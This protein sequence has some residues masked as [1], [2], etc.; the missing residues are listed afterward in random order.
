VLDLGKDWKWLTGISMIIFGP[1]MALCVAL[2]CFCPSA[3]SGEKRLKTMDDEYAFSLE[4][5][6]SDP[7]VVFR[8]L[9]LDSI[10]VC[11]QG[12]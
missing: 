6:S 1:C 12:V 9:E 4:S 3:W 8:L 11:V 5:G 2:P 7:S 10:C